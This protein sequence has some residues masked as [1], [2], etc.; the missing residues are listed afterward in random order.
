MNER[1]LLEQE[2]TSLGEE[3]RRPPSV[4][5]A[6]LRALAA[7]G[8]NLSRSMSATIVH[9]PQAATPAAPNEPGRHFCGRVRQRF[10]VST[11]AAAT[12][13]ACVLL[14]IPLLRAERVAFAKIR[15]RLASVRTASF[16][17]RHS[18]LRRLADGKSEPMEILQRISVRSDGR[19]RAELSNGSVWIMSQDDFIKLELDPTNRRATLRYLYDLE[20]KPDLLATLRSLHESVA[21]VAIPAKEIRGVECPGFRIEERQS[22][23]SVW[24]DRKTRLPVYA[25]RSFSKALGEDDPDVLRFD[26]VYEDMKFDEPLADE[27]FSVVPPAGYAVTTIGTPPADRKEI[28]DQPLVATANVGVGPLKFSMPRAEIIHLLGK[29][30]QETV[31][32]PNL[33]VDDNTIQVDGQARPQ[34]AALVV[35]TEFHTMNYDGLGFRLTVEAQ[36]GLTGIQCFGQDSLGAQG[37]TFRGATAEGIR[38]GSSVQDVL[39]AYG[40]PDEQS[41]QKL[42]YGPLHLKLALTE[43]QTVRSISLSDADS[44]PLRFEWRVPNN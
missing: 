7:D 6:V 17:L 23:L 36:D 5:K 9:G 22:T 30:D 27:M 2:L 11:I 28:F 4:A 15:E 42:S 14:V 18:V 24:V 43:R 38:I 37:R 3:L 32:V 16:T 12:V 41:D 33:T 25:E 39:K 10:V 20:E 13:L 26:E 19:M 1:D 35:L 34:G 40:K 8:A 21:A 31:H 44:H 29:P